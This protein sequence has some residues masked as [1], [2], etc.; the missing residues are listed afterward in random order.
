MMTKKHF[1]ALAGVFNA[2]F[3][4]LIQALIVVFKTDNK[5]FDADRFKAACF[6]DLI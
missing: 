2:T 5:N 4:H 6:K 1:Q 3:R